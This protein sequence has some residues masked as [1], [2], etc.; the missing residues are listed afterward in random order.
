MAIEAKLSK[1]KKN[2]YL[3][4]LF[5]FAGIGTWFAYDGYFNEKFQEKY[6]TTNEAGEEVLDS[7]L[8]FN[9]KSPPFF[10][11]GAI[12]AA[13]WLFLI[14]DKKVTASDTVLITEKLE[15]PYDNIEQIDK[16][17]FDSK[18]YFIITYKNPQGNE[19]TLRLSDRTYDNL[20]AILDEIVKQIT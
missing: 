6:T 4:I 7:T 17:N 12:A 5:V 18:G 8:V 9:R 20:P 11:A 3:I 16:T 14:K 1:Y 13:I 15:I 19:K 2:N 10:F